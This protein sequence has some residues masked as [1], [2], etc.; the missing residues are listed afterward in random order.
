VEGF[1]TAR[2]PSFTHAAQSAA[3]RRGAALKNRDTPFEVPNLGFVTFPTGKGPL[4]LDDRPH[5]GGGE[6]VPFDLSR[7]VRRE[8]PCSAAQ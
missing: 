6:P 7:K 1:S 2:N 5:L 3:A 8:Q 4:A